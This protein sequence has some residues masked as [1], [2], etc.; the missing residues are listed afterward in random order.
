MAEAS[1]ASTLTPEQQKRIDAWVK[2]VAPGGFA[3]T[4]CGTRNWTV[5]SDLLAPP[6][7]HGGGMVIGGPSYPHFGLACVNCGHTVFIN[8]VMSGV[9]TPPKPEGVKP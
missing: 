7:F 6:V 1:S 2:R 8:A 5:L 9:V 3:C 4:V